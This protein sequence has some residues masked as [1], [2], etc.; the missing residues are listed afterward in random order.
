MRRTFIYQEIPGSIAQ[1]HTVRTD[2][3]PGIVPRLGRESRMG[4]GRTRRSLIAP[5]HG[6]ARHHAASRFQVSGF[7]MKRAT[8]GHGTLSATQQSCRPTRAFARGLR[9]RHTSSPTVIEPGSRR[10]GRTDLPVGE[11]HALASGLVPDVQCHA[12]SGCGRSSGLIDYRSHPRARAYILRMEGWRRSAAGPMD[13]VRRRGSSR[14]LDVAS[15]R[16]VAGLQQARFHAGA[17]ETW[18]CA[19]RGGERRARDR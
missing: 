19:G 17:G 14:M 2:A 7:S 18:P 9:V 6:F 15:R 10:R 8:K 1:W 16:V 11:R 4:H 5:D 13:R 3:Y 12:R